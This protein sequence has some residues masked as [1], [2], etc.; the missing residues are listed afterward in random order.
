MGLERDVEA[1]RSRLVALRSGEPEPEPAAE[2]E[3]KRTVADYWC[4]EYELAHGCRDDAFT[5]KDAIILAR[6]AK[7]FV[8][9]ER[10]AWMIREFHATRDDEWLAQGGY[11]VEQ[12]AYRSR[13]LGLRWVKEI[14]E[15]QLR[16]EKLELE[17]ELRDLASE[18]RVL[19]LVKR[20]AGD[21]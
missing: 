12:L 16:R 5:S 4:A 20:V 21:P 9:A 2:P 14:R 17:R 1:L 13:G 19:A 11:G 7:Q 18:P 3:R 8:P 10:L 15:P 6:L